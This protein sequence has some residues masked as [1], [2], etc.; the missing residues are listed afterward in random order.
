LKNILQYLV[1]TCFFASIAITAIGQ[2]NE[3]LYDLT[4]EE[5]I[6]IN[7]IPSDNQASYNPSYEISLIDL[8][9]LEIVKELKIDT[10]IELTYDVPIEDLMQIKFNIKKNNAIEPTWDFSLVGLTS[11]KLKEDVSVQN[12]ID[13]SYDLSLDGVLQ[14]ALDKEQ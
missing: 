10:S 14:I 9:K 2:K 3:E 5:L 12:K 13:L 6:S 7:I 11:I 4:I 1:L 8:M